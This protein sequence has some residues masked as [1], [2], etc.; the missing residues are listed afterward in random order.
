MEK[1]LRN[2]YCHFSFLR[3][4]WVIQRREMNG[5]F[6]LILKACCF[7]QLS[8]PVWGFLRSLF[9]PVQPGKS[10]VGRACVQPSDQVTFNKF[11]FTK[12]CLA[13]EFVFFFLPKAVHKLLCNVAQ[14][15]SKQ[16]LKRCLYTL[17]LRMFLVKVQ[18]LKPCKQNKNSNHLVQEKVFMKYCFIDWFIDLVNDRMS[19]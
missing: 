3:L 1:S 5:P 10:A 12:P 18:A 19:E 4:A 14:T 15:L 11:C 13:V 7:T 16:L 9:C 2:N 8:S 6:K 17:F